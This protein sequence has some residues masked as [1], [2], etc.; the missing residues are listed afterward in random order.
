M[1]APSISTQ[2]P[3]SITWTRRED[4]YVRAILLHNTREGAR[5]RI[6]I[7]LVLATAALITFY[8]TMFGPDT[9]I[10]VLTT[11]FAIIGV[12][13]AIA[14]WGILP[15]HA[16]RTYRQH[17]SLHRPLTQT[18]S[19][20][21]LLSE[22]GDNRVFLP[23]SE[24]HRWREGAEEFL[25]YPSEVLFH[26]LPKRHLDSGQIESVRALLKEKVSGTSRPR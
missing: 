13:F 24:C 8:Y 25:V 15:R 17:K 23:W 6:V 5:R 7:P 18:V 3:I 1:T 12:L 26:M 10:V 16:R 4:D 19:D 11:V 22:E 20:E 21:G 14:R 9:V 2:A